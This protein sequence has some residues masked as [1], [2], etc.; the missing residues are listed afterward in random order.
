VKITL[1]TYGTRGDVQPYAVLGQHLARRGHDVTITACTN[2]VAMAEQAGLRT[3]PIPIDS[4]EFFASQRG[5]SIL[6]AGKT[7]VFLK[8]LGRQETQHRQGL[9]DALIRAC[10]GADLV[11]ASVLTAM[12]AAS[13]TQAGG[14][15]L[16]LVYT[17]PIEPTGLYPSPYLLPGRAIPTG[18]AR[19]GSHR[20]FEAVFWRGARA[21]VAVLRDRLGLPP[22]PG[23]ALAGLRR[24]R[25]PTLHLVSPRLLPTP[26]DWPPHLRNVGAPA[27]PV[28]L[29]TAWGE[30][31]V[32]PGLQDWL[33]AGEPPVFFGFGSM[34]VLDPSSAA[35]MISATARRLGVRALIG[36]GWSG[37]ATGGHDETTFIADRLDH[38]LVLPRCRAAVH[39]GGAGTTHAALRA[40]LPALVAHVFADQSL[41]GQRVRELGT[42]TT[43]PYRS[44]NL[45]RLEKALRPL[46]RSDIKARAQSISLAM[47]DEQ[48]I[49]AVTSLIEA[50]KVPDAVT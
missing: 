8:E 50:G 20:L 10:Q 2:L 39:H 14:Q 11:V 32:A 21:N 37:L 24:R 12:R 33:D 49:D 13:I 4:Q 25:V 30:G 18:L 19:R 36:A 27:A 41:W 3:V 26:A 1:L 9:D 38:D 43:M 7:T 44:L 42:G 23:N 46:L 47:R 22:Q 29:R 40:G 15:R 17:L 48:P 45:R 31:T 35:E 34:P 5:R 6:A 16:L 28:Q